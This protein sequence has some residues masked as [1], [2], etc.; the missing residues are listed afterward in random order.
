MFEGVYICTE[1]GKYVFHN[2]AAKGNITELRI[3]H[4]REC[5]ICRENLPFYSFV[6]SAARDVSNS[7]QNNEVDGRIFSRCVYKDFSML[8]IIRN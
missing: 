8:G 2:A 4:V 6:G 1:H 3:D 7:H 5:N